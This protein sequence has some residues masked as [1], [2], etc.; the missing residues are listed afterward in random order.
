MNRTQTVDDWMHSWSQAAMEWAHCV[1]LV[2]KLGTEQTV[3]DLEEM[4]C[5]HAH[6]VMDTLRDMDKGM[7]G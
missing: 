7:E 5:L 3:A 1:M 2:R 6:A 4:V